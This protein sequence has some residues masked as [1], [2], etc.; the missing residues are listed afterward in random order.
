MPI[1][2]PESI[3][4]LRKRKPVTPIEPEKPELPKFEPE[5]IARFKARPEILPSELELPQLLRRM[6]PEAYEL[7]D[8]E[9]VDV[10][11]GWMEEEPDAFILEMKERGKTPETI[12]LL[13]A[14]EATPEEIEQIFAVEVIAPPQLEVPDWLTFDFWKEALFKPYAGEDLASKAYFSFVAGIGDVIATSGGAARWLG[15]EDVG[16]VLSSIGSKIQQVAPPD[17]TGEFE[18]ADLLNPEWYATKIARTIPFALSLAPWAIGGFY[19][20]SAIATT[21]GLGRLGAWLVGGFSGAALSRPLESAL[22]AGGQYDDAIARGKTE[23]EAK[24]EADE[25]FRN[26]MTLAGLDAFQIAIALAPTPKWVP[27]SLVRAGLVRTTRIAGKMVIIG[28]TEGGEEVYQD[29]VQRHARGEEWQLDPVSKEVFAIGMVMG[30]GMGLGGD[31]VTGLV[32]NVKKKMSLDIKGDFYA[33]VED[34]EAQ[35]FRI[36][37]SELKALD[38]ISQTPEGEKIVTETLKEL[39][40]APTVPIIPEVVPEA[41]LPLDEVSKLE[42]RIPLDLIRKDEAA[43]IERLTG[44]IEK[45]GITEPITIRVREDGSRIVWDGIHRLI[46]AQNLGIE[47]VPVRFIGEVTKPPVAK[48]AIE[49]PEV[50]GEGG[51]PVPPEEPIPQGVIDSNPVL[52]NIGWKEAA[53]P[54]RKVFERLGLF[55]LH[56][57][58]QKA[59]VLIGEERVARQKEQRKL[60]KTVDKERWSL[61]FDEV[62]EKGSVVGLTFN[63]KRAVAYIR[64]WANEWAERKNLPKEKRIKD[65]IPHLF[66]QEMIA[67]A[68]ET[69]IIPPE[70]AMIL[71][72]RVAKKITDPFLKERLGAVGFLKDPFRAMEAYDAAAMKVLYYE[73]FLQK[74]AT[75]ANDPIQRSDVRDYMK[76]YSRRMTSEPNKHDLK[77]NADLQ[78]IASKL[79]KVPGGKALAKFLSQGNPSGLVAYQFTGAIYAMW[80]G[81]KPTSAIRNLSQHTLIIGEVGPVHFAD[82]IRLRFTK[83]GKAALKK[84]LVLRSRKAAFVPGIDDSFAE[85]WTDQFRETALWMFRFADRQNVSDAFLAGYSEAKSLLPRADEQVWIDRGDEVAADTQYLYTKM[86]SMAVSQSA[87]GRVFSILT[88]WSENWIELMSKW[89]ARRP[90]QVYLEHERATGEK[91]AG[92]NWATSVKAIGIYMAIIGLGYAL[93]E[94]TRLKAWEYTGITSI[95]YLADVLGGD[96]PGLQYIG[97]AANIIAGFATDDERRLKEGLYQL[98]PAKMVGIIRQLNAVMAGDKD[99]LTLLFYLEGR[100]YKFKQLKNKWKKDFKPYNELAQ[101]DRKEY[102]E[103]NPKIEA[104]LF[105]TSQ[106]TTLSSDAARAEVLRLIEEH[107]L[108]TEMID[109]YEKVFGVDTA[110]ELD[111]FQNRVGNLEKLEVGVEAEYYTMNDFASEVNILVKN[112]GRTKVEKDGNQLAVEYLRAKDLFVQYDSLEGDARKQYRM[113]FP[114]VEALMY[115]FGH[116]NLSAFQNPN[117]A[118]ELLRLMKKYDIPPEGIK[119]FVDDPAKYDALQAPLFQLQLEWN[120]MLIAYELAEQE[121]RELMLEENPKFRDARRQIEAINK[122][123]PENLVMSYV[124][125]YAMDVAG[126]EQERFLKENEDYYKEVW[127]GI[128]ENEEKDF[129]RVP[130]KEFENATNEYEALKTTEERLAFLEQHEWFRRE[131][132][133]REA[134]DKDIPERLRSEYVEYYEFPSTGYANERYLMEHKEFYRYMVDSGEW[135]EKDFSKVA[136]EK[137]EEALVDYDKLELGYDRYEYRGNNPWFDEEGVKLEKWQP[138]DPEE[139]IPRIIV[140]MLGEYDALPTTG[141]DR[142]IFRHTHP[143]LEEWLV[144]QRGYIP[145]GDRWKGEVSRRKPKKEEAEEKETW[146]EELEKMREKLRKLRG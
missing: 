68:K 115:L 122:G 2:E 11:L 58:I 7:E 30:L 85:K 130:T 51:I 71:S 75:I 106:F 39:Q 65:Y 18:L 27:T 113:Q 14:F 70:L 97:A 109:G 76:D 6:W 13:E 16:G 49:A 35:G 131:R 114:D 52:R 88:T 19:G 12:A 138:F 93:K 23:Q 54:T 107:D 144:E 5:T 46:V 102:R 31:V 62:N 61:V 50:I 59:E 142:L 123:V 112:M 44:E 25:V 118:V 124:E 116:N 45:E 47:N 74:I 81:F 42:T 94:E 108:D 120:E 24:E 136:T 141:R 53:R 129:D 63:E 28:L 99:W 132:R 3:A 73:P 37:Q 69:G 22:E 117:S 9:V 33:A 57:G 87:P 121:E 4:R 92:A 15:Y 17:T 26:N 78:E 135:I 105:I 82:A 91:V 36:D 38:T 67:Q 43:A 60:M 133:E 128:L 64:N 72:D 145:V 143:K 84:S 79:E 111:K 104:K 1:T 32:D 101:K 134:V 103:N 8:V 89:I 21:L 98:N 80:L 96:F 40:E 55:R 125:Y 126:W 100:N 86:N 66:E 140:L 20:G 10:M 90:S 41:I 83:E 139:F 137:F 48:E 110:V 119:A 77:I 29:M 95:R 146:T 34:W 56:K 127:L